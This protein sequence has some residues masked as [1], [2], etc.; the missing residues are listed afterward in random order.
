M[1]HIISV[2]TL[3]GEMRFDIDKMRHR[4]LIPSVGADTPKGHE[5]WNTR[6]YDIMDSW[7]EVGVVE[8]SNGSR[9]F[10]YVTKGNASQYKRFYNKDYMKAFLFIAEYHA[11]TGKLWTDRNKKIGELA[12]CLVWFSL[13]D[14]PAPIKF[15][16]DDFSPCC[17]DYFSGLLW[18]T[19]SR[20]YPWK[21]EWE[22]EPVDSLQLTLPAIPA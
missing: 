11:S 6:R 1:A 19:S 7:G 22:E 8:R 12:E 9:K 5:Q 2:E 18:K 20:I 16:L 3:V 10:L 4:P 13:T 21:P 15:S 14:K 17:E